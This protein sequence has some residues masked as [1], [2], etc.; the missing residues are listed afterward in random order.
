MD[1]AEFLNLKDDVMTKLDE[2]KNEEHESLG[3]EEP[4][5]YSARKERSENE[6]P[7]HSRS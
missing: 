5:A 1:L 2:V 6:K 3:V 4:L 7:K